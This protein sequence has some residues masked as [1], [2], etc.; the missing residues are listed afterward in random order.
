MNRGAD[1]L[2]ACLAACRERAGAATGPRASGQQRSI[3][4]R[5]GQPNLQLVSHIGRDRAAVPYMACKGSGVQIPS[6]PLSISAGQTVLTIPYGASRP[7][8]SPY[9]VT[10]LDIPTPVTSPAVSPCTCTT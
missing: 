10:A 7:A 4:V 1:H 9:P 5:N 2:W 6:A 3:T 8:G